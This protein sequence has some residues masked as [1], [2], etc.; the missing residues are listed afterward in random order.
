MRTH[1]LMSAIAV[2]S[3]AGT[4]A[5]G[6][7]A[8]VSGTWSLSV[9]MENAQGA[10]TVVLKQQGQTVTGTVTNASGQQK[11]TGAVKGNEVVFGFETTREGQPF[12][13]SYRGTIES[14]RRM[15]GEVTFS[16]VLSGT[17]TWVATK[18]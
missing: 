8:D 6:Q 11:V 2:V 3:L 10:P 5:A 9:V 15:T 17:G 16:G 13:A 4:V 7:T 18:E 12:R 14:P 1:E